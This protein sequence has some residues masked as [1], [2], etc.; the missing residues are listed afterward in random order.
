KLRKHQYRV[1]SLESENKVFKTLINNAQI[2]QM[3]GVLRRTDH[4]KEYKF[5][6]T[7]K[8]VF[9]KA[10]NESGGYDLCFETEYI[11]I[12]DEILTKKVLREI[13]KEDVK[14]DYNRKSKCIKI[15]DDDFD[16]INLVKKT[17][18]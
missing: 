12:D 16:L 6:D 9:E 7:R 3:F 17:M 10:V 13:V 5:V 15:H 4:E 2:Q 11:T 8:R 14:Y 1:T 18:S